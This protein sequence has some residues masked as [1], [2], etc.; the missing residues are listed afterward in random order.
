MKK[1]VSKSFRLSSELFQHKTNP[2]VPDYDFDFAVDLLKQIGEKR[3]Y[4]QRLTFHPGQFNVLGTPRKKPFNKQLKIQHIMLMFLI[5]W[6]W[7]K[8]QLW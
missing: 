5:L 7:V 8:I 1:M 4:N 6:K 3:N 2:K